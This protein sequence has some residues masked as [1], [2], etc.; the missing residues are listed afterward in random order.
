MTTVTDPNA[1]FATERREQLAS[2]ADRQADLQARIDAGTLVPL[3]DGKYRVNDPGSWDNG[4][5]WY[6][7]N[8]LILPQ[9]QL[10]MST[11]QAAL[12]T[13]VPAW[14]EL[15]NVVPEGVT[16]IDEVMRLGGIDFE[17]EKHPAL[18][19]IDGELHVN[20]DQFATVRVNRVGVTPK[21]AGLGAVGTKYTP[22][23]NREQF[24]FLEDLTGKFGVTWESAGA[25]RG[26]RSVFVCMRLPEEVRIDAAG[27]NDLIVPFI[28]A[29]NSHDGSSQ[30]QVVVTPWR[31]VC[32][33]TER[34]AVR[35]AV[36]RWGVRH[37]RNAMQ[38]IDEARRTLGFSVAYFEEFAREEQALAQT[39][40][41]LA[42]FDR[43]MSDLWGEPDD[44]ASQRAKTLHTNRRDKLVANWDTNTER[45]GRT[46]YAAERAI[47]QYAD[48]DKTVAPRGELRGKNLA[49]RATAM[50]EGSD[51]ALKSKAHKRLLILTR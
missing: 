38:R 34:F 21:Y 30:A 41:E 2:I 24:T 15:G 16:D 36:T 5:V 27:I 32:G 40:M 50:L 14:H 39:E 31:P 17:V 48:W 29:V 8:G 10:D 4:E 45:L 11:G 47:T 18:F 33:N 3:G 46:A 37:T 25:V 22:L 49:T 35:D 44:D 9:H 51:D 20:P 26:G 7:S 42:E 28:V 19:M 12:Y 13:T 1:A 23:Q 43:V 6:Q